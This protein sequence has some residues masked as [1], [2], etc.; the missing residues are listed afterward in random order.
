M[1]LLEASL[2]LEVKLR[3]INCFQQEYSLF[4]NRNLDLPFLN[5][6]RFCVNFCKL[7]SSVIYSAHITYSFCDHSF[8]LMMFSVPYPNCNSYRIGSYLNKWSFWFCQDTRALPALTNKLGQFFRWKGSQMLTIHPPS[9]HRWEW[10]LPL[11]MKSITIVIQIK[12]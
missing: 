5:L 3:K 1:G 2:R 8:M 4:P 10:K 9:F 7:H 12:I 6:S 11:V